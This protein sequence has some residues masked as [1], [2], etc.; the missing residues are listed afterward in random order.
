[1]RHTSVSM[2]GPSYVV[3]RHNGISLPHTHTNTHLLTHTHTAPPPGSDLSPVLFTHPSFDVMNLWFSRAEKERERAP[4]PSLSHT[5]G[6]SNRSPH[7]PEGWKTRTPRWWT[8]ERGAPE[9]GGITHCG[10]ALI[11]GV[12][13]Y[14]FKC[15]LV[16]VLIHMCVL[17]ER[18][19]VCV[20]SMPCQVG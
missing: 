17:S 9:R 5:A 20:F 11:Q 18:E 13:V 1:M 12:C 2:R 4:L 19:C 16:C 6:H 14:V 7:F 15:E 8:T 10:Q 3:K